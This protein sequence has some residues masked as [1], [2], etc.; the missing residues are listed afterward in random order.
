MTRKNILRQK[1]PIF[2][3]RTKIEEIWRKKSL[4]E[5]LRV[6]AHILTTYAI[7]IRTKKFEMH[8]YLNSILENYDIDF[9]INLK[10][11]NN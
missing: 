3:S 11:K 10:N 1:S 5:E 6:P 8:L 9:K 7:L 2:A 4:H